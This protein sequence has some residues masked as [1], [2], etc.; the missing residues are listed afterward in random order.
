MQR[1]FVRVRTDGRVEE[2]EI[3]PLSLSLSLSLYVSRSPH[4][5][6]RPT[7]AMSLSDGSDYTYIASL[8]IISAAHALQ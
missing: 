1:S 5:E 8:L 3:E 6:S 4:T 7:D 2:Q